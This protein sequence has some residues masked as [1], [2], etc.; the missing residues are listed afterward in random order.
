MPQQRRSA[1]S[2][3]GYQSAH[4]TGLSVQPHLLEISQAAEPPCHDQIPRNARGNRL[5]FP[6]RLDAFFSKQPLVLVIDLSI[7]I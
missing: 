7:I 3:R 6:Q 1:H 5:A 2:N 4:R